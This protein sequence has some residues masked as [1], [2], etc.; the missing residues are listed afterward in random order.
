MEGRTRDSKTLCGETEGR[1]QKNKHCLLYTSMGLQQAIEDIRNFVGDRTQILC[2]MNGVESEEKVA[3]AYGWNHVLYSYMR[4]SIVMKNGRADFDP[5]WGKAVSYTHLDV[6]KRQVLLSGSG[7]GVSL[8]METVFMSS[9]APRFWIASRPRS[10][11][12]QVVPAFS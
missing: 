2:V 5:Y 1:I 7:S 10:S 3:A 11:S 4:M 8:S 9:F 6:Y 12:V